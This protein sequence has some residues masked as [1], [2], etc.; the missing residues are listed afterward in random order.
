MQTCNLC[1]YYRWMFWDIVLATDGELYKEF[2]QD[3]TQV[4]LKII[5]DKTEHSTGLSAL[6]VTTEIFLL[7]ANLKAPLSSTQTTS[8]NKFQ[9]N[10]LCEL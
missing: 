8:V 4:F 9:N 10:T 2:C 6:L 5:G 7:W 3:I 1:P